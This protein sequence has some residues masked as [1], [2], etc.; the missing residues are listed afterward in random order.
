[1]HNSIV[2]ESCVIEEELYKAWFEIKHLNLQNLFP[3]HFQAVDTKNWPSV[4]IY[5][6]DGGQ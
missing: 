5:T 6:Q 1:M 4:T 2:L 3:G